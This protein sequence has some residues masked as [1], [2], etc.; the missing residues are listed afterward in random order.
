MQTQLAFLA[1]FESF[2]QIQNL[3]TYKKY[4]QLQQ[5]IQRT[6][7]SIV[8]FLEDDELLHEALNVNSEDAEQI[9]PLYKIIDEFID[10]TLATWRQIDPF[11]FAGNENLSDEFNDFLAYS[12]LAFSKF[13]ELTE[14]FRVTAEN[15]PIDEQSIEYQDFAMEYTALI[16]QKQPQRKASKSLRESLGI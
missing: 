11:I 10:S 4:V 13:K 16:E 3:L 7:P 9:Y 1:V 8:R 12:L 5:L 14:I 15:H 6:K 2:A